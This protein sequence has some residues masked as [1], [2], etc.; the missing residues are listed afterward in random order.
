MEGLLAVECVGI[1]AILIVA[2][3]FLGLAISRLQVNADRW[4][5]SFALVAKRF[6]GE[7]SRGGWFHNPTLKLRYGPT[8][9]R[10]AAYRY[11]GS[12]G[13]WC[14]EMVVHLPEPIQTRCEIAPRSANR[15][16]ARNARGLFEIELDWGDF[17]N[18]WQVLTDDGD[19]ATLLLSRAVRVQLD[20]LWRFPFRSET[21]VSLFPSWLIIRKLWD[22]TRPV[23]LESFAEA[24]LSLFDQLQ[25][26]R[27][28]GI[29]FVEDAGPTIIEDACCQICGEAMVRDIVL[30]R[31]CKTPHHRD[32]WHYAGNC[33][34]YGCGETEYLL[35]GIPDPGQFPQQKPAKPR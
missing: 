20:R 1:S 6:G 11:G 23:E 21:S 32:C 34:T 33:S 31:R 35:P 19:T 18:N 5:R 28:A 26:A 24:A 17:R 10:L 13:P 2:G 8:H 27:T 25:L 22:T 4:N 30:C 3:I 29:E 15:R 12:S 7:F 14:L 16:M 9:A